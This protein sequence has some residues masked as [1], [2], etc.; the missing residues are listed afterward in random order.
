MTTPAQLP[1][2]LY[3]WWL[4]SPQKP[5]LIGALRWV[6]RA[7]HHHAG[8]S[9]RYAPA[10]LAHG[11]ALSEDMPLHAADYLPLSPDVAAGAV[12]DARPDRWGERVIR[13]L[14]KPQ[15]L[16]TLDYLY[17]AGDNRVGALGVSESADVYVPHHHGVLP[18]LADV[19]Q[20]HDVIRRVEANE[21][22]EA[23]VLRLVT[24][25]ATLGGA[26]PK[27]LLQMDGVEWVLK[28][29]EKGDVVDVGLIEHASMTL[30]A[31]AGIDVC[32]THALP[33]LQT[34]QIKH[35][36]AVRRFD[37]AGGHRLHCI[38][39]H[40]GLRAAG[41]DY[42]YPEMALLM[43][44]LGESSGLAY[45]GEQFFRRMVFN[46]FIDNTDDHE[47]NHM[48]IGQEN[49]LKLAPAF[50]VLPTLQSL[51]VQS[52]R[53]GKTGAD[54][55]LSNALSEHK[56]FGLSLLRARQL[57]QEVVA[58]VNEWQ[59]HFILAG[60]ALHDVQTVAQHVDRDFLF[61]QRQESMPI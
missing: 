24:P 52:I 2:V 29:A 6:R 39:A 3:L 5:K 17:F 13:F 7:L 11:F 51:G 54:S 33:Y 42:G 43:R 25:G 36:V 50:D 59:A 55:K 19:Q 30:A 27:A 1:D 26:K 58:A 20:M 9:L 61:K 34:G 45:V 47:K 14:I 48:F 41:A 46:I 60:V 12:D 10:W 4:G 37:R 44:R 57:A 23:S 56:L 18:K 16:S 38:S 49:R 21:P 32:E 31:K 22:L 53:V 8:V 35:A 28:F 40:V 15:R